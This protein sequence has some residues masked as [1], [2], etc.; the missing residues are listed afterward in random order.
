MAATKLGDI[1]E[2]I[3][4]IPFDDAY[5]DIIVIERNVMTIATT[6]RIATKHSDENTA[7]WVVRELGYN[8]LGEMVYIKRISESTAAPAWAQAYL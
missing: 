6:R 2:S 7:L 8:H 3:S 4:A 5:A 1:G